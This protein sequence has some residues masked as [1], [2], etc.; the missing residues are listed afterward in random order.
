MRHGDLLALIEVV[1][2]QCRDTSGK[3]PLAAVRRM[4]DIGRLDAH[5]LQSA[6]AYPSDGVYF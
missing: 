5:G 4:P 6:L 3:S 2:G 1:P